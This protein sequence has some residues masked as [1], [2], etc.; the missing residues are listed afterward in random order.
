MNKITSF[1][2]ILLFILLSL[3]PIVIGLDNESIKP[4]NGIIDGP[5]D[6][7]WSTYGHDNRHTSQSLYST[8]D[9]SGLIKWKLLADSGFHSSPVI[10]NNGII[11]IGC[12]DHY[13]YAINPDGTEKWKFDCNGW[14]LSSPSLYENECIYVG[15]LDDSLYAINLDGTLRWK[16][17]AEGS[18]WG[19]PTIS[20]DGIIY[21][22]SIGPD[23]YGR[24]Y[25]LYPNGTEKWHY[26]TGDWIYS[27]PAIANNN[28]IYITSNNKYLY[29]L[30]SNDGSLLW[31]FRAGDSLSNPSIDDDGIIYF[32]SHDD[33]LYAI[34]PNG[35]MKWRTEIDTGSSDTPAIGSDGTIY[36]GGFYFYAVNP[37]G[38]IKW[39]Y[40]GWEP[41]EYECTSRTYAISSDGNIYF[42][43][44]KHG[45]WGGNLIALN[46]DGTLRWRK[47]I[48]TND[49]QYSSPAI[50]LH[51]TVYIG[52]KYV[53]SGYLY[54]DLF[55]FGHGEVNNNITIEI[56]GGIGVEIIIKNNGDSSIHDL[57]I[58]IILDSFWMIAG[59]ETTTTISELLPQSEI[60]VTTGFFF[61]LGPFEVTVNI[62]DISETRN[63][64]IFGPFVIL[65]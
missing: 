3:H 53:D 32:S 23:S 63:G 29:A 61:G 36:I 42:V 17:D 35:T 7:P 50:D 51:G 8:A 9:N 34:Y 64:F 30:S 47:N 60:I 27:T 1:L 15:S 22:G 16:Y 21:F 24:V 20:D 55:A 48:A 62:L 45:G 11:Y 39:I 5:M 46:H 33:Y 59:G 44:T 54:G 19:S 38:S 18:I 6:S 25:A 52:S 37:D 57:E 4:S 58:S 43:A 56:N 2:I 41:Y 49:Y 31:R 14:I 12:M 10:D 13:L 26:D 65:K 40:Q 28:T